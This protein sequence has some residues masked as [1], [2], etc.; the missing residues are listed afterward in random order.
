MTSDVQAENDRPDPDFVL[1]RY[2]LNE[3]PAGETARLER[4]AS[5]DARLRERLSALDRSDAAI[6]REAAVLAAGVAARLANRG[7]DR[8]AS[9]PLRVGLWAA[10]SMAAALLLA[11]ALRPAP[12]AGAPPTADA[13]DRIK[14]P[15]A[16]MVVYRQTPGG[17]ERLDPGA[18]AREGDVVRVGYR[19]AGP[20]FG[21]IF[22]VDGRGVVTRHFPRDRAEAAPLGDGQIVLL[23]RAYELDDA[24]VFERFYFIAGRA[25]FEVGPVIDA[26]RAAGPDP[27]PEALAIDPSL[28]QATFFLAKDTRP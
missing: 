26:A 5:R 8:R 17:S 3:L 19:V 6:R 11:V 25:P 20:A 2:R 16:T 24:P 10:G 23:D 1:E 21:V 4:Q 7:G 28:S 27:A 13:G 15:A 18:H 9:R 12:R 22:S 14:G